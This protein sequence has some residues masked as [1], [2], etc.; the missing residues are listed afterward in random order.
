MIYEYL[1]QNYSEGEPIF[2]SELPDISK[3]YVQREMKKLADTGKVQRLK[4][5]FIFC[6]IPQY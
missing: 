5:A 6:H 2:L 4:M 1:V 3:N